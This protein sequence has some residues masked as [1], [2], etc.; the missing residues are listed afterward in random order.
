MIYYSLIVKNLNISGGIEKPHGS[1]LQVE[2]R[3]ENR[4]EESKR[5]MHS[6]KDSVAKEVE[7]QKNSNIGRMLC[8]CR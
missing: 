5:H 3:L 1:S 2:E 4:I 6:S 7:T 8:H